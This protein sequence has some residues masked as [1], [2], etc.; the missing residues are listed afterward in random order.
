[1]I[2]DFSQY[3]GTPV[4]D[5][6]AGLHRRTGMSSDGANRRDDGINDG[7]NRHDDGIN[8]GINF[9]MAEEKAIKLIL[10]M[11]SMTAVGLA[12]ALGLKKRQAERIIASLKKKAGLVR[13]GSRKSGTWRFPA[14]IQT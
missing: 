9:S 5:A 13:E 14:N 6:V 10:R 12:G 7:I 1:M 11:P 8:D 3:Y 2:N 4:A